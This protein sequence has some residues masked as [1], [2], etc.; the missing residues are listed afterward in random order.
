MLCEAIFR[1][2]TAPRPTR[3]GGRMDGQSRL[4]SRAAA[5]PRPAI[6]VG[7]PGPIARRGRA[8]GAPRE[9]RMEPMR[10]SPILFLAGL[11]LAA[12]LA[13][14]GSAAASSPAP[15][16]D[17]PPTGDIRPRLEIIAGGEALLIVDRMARKS[18]AM[19]DLDGPLTSLAISPDGSRIWLGLG[20]T[21]ESGG[22]LYLFDRASR[23]V[24][25]HVTTEPVR[26]IHLGPKPR[27]LHL[28]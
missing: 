23:R 14:G 24:V 18:A 2:G 13:R 1:P 27:E 20:G 25:E 12:S 5:A 11:A 17:P 7:S 6:L 19:I 26:E 15:P 16:D 28:L 22:G 8:V 10:R 3:I 4:R 9:P 21:K